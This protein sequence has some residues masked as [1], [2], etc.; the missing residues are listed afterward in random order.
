MQYL[1]RTPSPPLDKFVERIWYCADASTHAR[2]RVLPSGGSIDLGFNLA[3]DEVRIYDVT[4][5]ESVRVHSG[6]IVCGSYTHSYFIDPR[7]RA[8]V[9]GAHF[10]PG[11]AFAF[12]GISPW[13]I[14]DSHVQLH[15]LWGSSSRSLREQLIE[16]GSPSDQLRILEEAL[17]ARLRRARPGHPAVG[18]AVDALRTATSEARVAQVAALV[19]LSHRRFIEVFER[20]VGLTPKVYARIQRFHR[21]KQRIAALGS[22]PSWASFA[23]ECGYC[24]QS[25]MIRDFAAFSGMSPASYLR[26]RTN[27]TMFDHLV[28]AYPNHV[29]AR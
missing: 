27:E 11:G 5:P 6:A 15:D 2:E 8:S 19:G 25:H 12:L 24:D 14:V 21:V 13:E 18:V 16:A 20:E 3:E 23:L 17:Q 9:L 26:C 10:R 28:H 1:A 22:P 7:Q 29:S 4:N